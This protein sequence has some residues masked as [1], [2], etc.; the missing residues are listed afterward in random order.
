[1]STE[2]MV[3]VDHWRNIVITLIDPVLSEMAS[4]LPRNG[5]Q[6]TITVE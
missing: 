2:S 6:P 1:V 5:S 3:Y 4:P